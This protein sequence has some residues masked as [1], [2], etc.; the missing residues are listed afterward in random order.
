MPSTSG[1]I[2]PTNACHGNAESPA[3]PRVTMVRNGP[4]SRLITLYA[5]TSRLR[6][7]WPINDMYMPPLVSFSAA[8]TASTDSPA[9]SPPEIGASPSS[10]PSTT[11]TMTA[12]TILLPS[13]AP[14]FLAMYGVAFTSSV[15]PRHT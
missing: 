13:S 14:P 15:A 1:R 10:R 2:A 7:N 12:K 8:T 3:I 11:P 5:P 6:P 4:D 9:S